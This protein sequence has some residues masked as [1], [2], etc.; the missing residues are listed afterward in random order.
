ML[1]DELGLEPGQALRGAHEQ[2]LRSGS[3]QEPPAAEGEQPEEEAA[4]PPQIVRTPSQLPFDI[5]DF[6]G[7][8]VEVAALRRRLSEE[9]TGSRLCAVYG[10][11]GAGKSTLA[12]HVAHR[13]R[14]HFP[15][16][17]LYASLRGVR[18]VRADPAEVLAGFLRALGVADSAIPE[19]QDER[20][21]LY[22]TMLADRRILVVLDDAFD[23]GQVRPLLPGGHTS[24]ALVTSR[25][26]LGA[27]SG[28]TQLDL[29]VLTDDEALQL[30]DKVVGDGRVPA[31]QE[32]AREIVRL[33]GGLPLAV[34]IAGARLAAR[35]RWRVSRMVDRLRVQ[36]RV[37]Q[38]LSIG[39]LE[40]RGSSR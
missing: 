26:R 1:L 9:A 21:R 5:A 22:R 39:D 36:H 24:A 25:E 18:T 13:V 32:A 40:V 31:E 28:A 37:L 16:G 33:C 2:V 14:E 35:S 10:K 12:M 29:H 30:L 34:R 19:E 27:L 20:A 3:E 23:E 38:E 7:R 4:E 8:V 6:T 11:P 15:D 17:Q